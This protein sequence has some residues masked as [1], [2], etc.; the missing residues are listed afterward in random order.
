MSRSR[1]KPIFKDGYGSKSKRKAK[2]AANIAVKHS[3]DL[4]RGSQYKKVYCSWNIADFRFDC[5]FDDVSD[6]TPKEKARRVR[7]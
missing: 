3:K 1:R 6:L 2:K 7:K 4:P 5:R